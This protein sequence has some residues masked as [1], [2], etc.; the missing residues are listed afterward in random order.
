MNWFVDFFQNFFSENIL[1]RMV[2]ALKDMM[3]EVVQMK[4]NVLYAASNSTLKQD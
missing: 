4:N 3:M 2:L 1:Y